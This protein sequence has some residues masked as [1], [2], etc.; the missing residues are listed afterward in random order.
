MAQWH[1]APRRSGRYGPDGSSRWRG[2]HGP[3]GSC[4]PRRQDHPARELRHLPQRWQ[5][6]AANAAHA[7]TG[8]VSVTNVTFVVDGLDLLVKYNAKIDGQPETGITTVAPITGSRPAC[9]ATR[10]P[11]RRLSPAQRPATS[12]SDCWVAQ[13]TGVNSRYFFRVSDKARPAQPA[14]AYRATS[15]PPPMRISRV[16]WRAPTATAPGHRSAHRLPYGYPWMKVSDC[17]VCHDAT[18]P[19]LP[20]V[21]NLMKVAHSVHNSH[22]MPAGEWEQFG[23]R[24][25]YPTYMTNCSVCHDPPAT[26]RCGECDAVT[27]PTASAAMARSRVG[28][29]A[30]RRAA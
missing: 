3:D 20:D 16:R 8:Q 30:S 11:R 9:R 29:R 23:I 17:T 2:S 27:R 4:G 19:V 6:F 10:A 21:P 13:R 25:T 18:I 15:R 12:R 24:V 14:S 5:S 7:L 22:Q 26:A 1:L 28:R